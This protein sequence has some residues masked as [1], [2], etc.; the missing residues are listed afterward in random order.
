MGQHHFN[1]TAIAAKKGEL[2][3]KPEKMGK[4]ESER[5]LLAEIQRKIYEPICRCYVRTTKR[6]Y[7]EERENG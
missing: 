6:S 7:K 2:P 1:P 5:I 3:P 4:R